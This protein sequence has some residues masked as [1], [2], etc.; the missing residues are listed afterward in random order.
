MPVAGY[1]Q[2]KGS[3]RLTGLEVQGYQVGICLVFGEGLMTE[4]ENRE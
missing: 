2:R 3:F 4:K 1:L